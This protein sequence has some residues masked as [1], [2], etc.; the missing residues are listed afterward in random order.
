MDV[1]NR[2]DLDAA[3]YS[4]KRIIPAFVITIAVAFCLYYLIGKIQGAAEGNSYIYDFVAL[5][6]GAAKGDVAWRGAWFM[7]DITEG[8]FIGSL[9]ATIMV[10]IGSYIGAYLE[11]KKSPAMGTGVDGNGQIFTIMTIS[12]FIALIL[13]PI[14]Y[15]SF[16]NSGL[17]VPS[18]AAFLSVQAMVVNFNANTIPKAL[19]VSVLGSLVNLPICFWFVKYFTAP[20]N[21]PLFC[22]VGLSIIITVPLCSEIMHRLP[23]MKQTPAPEATATGSDEGDAAVAESASES[24]TDMLQDQTEEKLTVASESTFFINRI[25][26]D[27]GEMILWGSSI[28]VILMYIGYIVGAYLNPAH[29]AFN[30]QIVIPAQLITGAVGILIWY[31]KWKE[32]GWVFTFAPLLFSSAIAVTYPFTWQI[33][34][35][36]ILISTICIPPLIGWLLK[37]TG[38]KGRWHVIPYVL[39]SICVLCIPWSFFVANVLAK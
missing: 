30:P 32:E 12:G 22:A 38:Y 33:M 36:T 19:T 13:G 39:T 7:A 34:V 3:K 31:P 4:R 1:A 18:F 35:P 17:F 10:L 20:N 15:S 27:V 26:G 5:M 16:F 14:V 24:T 29:A 28:G 8:T 37:V 9:P 21:L 2:I 23:W 11:R 6:T 25:F